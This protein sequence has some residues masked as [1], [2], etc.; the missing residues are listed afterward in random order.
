MSKLYGYVWHPRTGQQ[1]AWVKDGKMNMA[2]G[3]SYTLVGDMIV[4]EDGA[5][6][7]HLSTF[8][9]LSEGSGDLANHLIQRR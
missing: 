5:E 7:G 9:G 1:I 2:N 3:K 6:L 4:D 8:V